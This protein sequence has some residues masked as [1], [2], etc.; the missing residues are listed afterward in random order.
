MGQYTSNRAR[1]ARVFLERVRN[2][3]GDSFD[4]FFAS[5]RPTLDSLPVLDGKFF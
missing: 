3:T 1:N 2:R 5:Y 4:F